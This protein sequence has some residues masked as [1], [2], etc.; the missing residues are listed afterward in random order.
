MEGNVGHLLIKA[1]TAAPYYWKRPLQT[2][3]TMLGEWLRTG[4]MFY[5][6]SDGYFYF[7]GRSDD[8][9]KVGGMW[10]SPVEVESAIVAH[11]A[12]VEAGVIGRP[13]DDGLTKPHAFVVLKSDIPPSDALAAEI[14]ESVRKRLAGYKAP[15]WVE[16]VPD[17]PKTATGKVQRFR[18][19]SKD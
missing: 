16:F 13:D 2:R 17:L 5:Q 1:P 7:C 4:D 3:A 12:V 18:L 9:L 6:D 19:R 11:P 10:V 15:R 14:R 8:M